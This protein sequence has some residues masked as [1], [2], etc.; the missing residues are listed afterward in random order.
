M[1]QTTLDTLLKS[2]QVTAA[3]PLG[4]ATA[5]HPGLYRS[6]DVLALEQQEIFAKEWLCL[7]RTSDIAK[8]G[9][10]LTFAI[11]DQPV[12][13]F[14]TSDGSIKTHANVCLH[15]MMRLLDGCGNAKRIVCPYHAWTYDI[16]GRLIGAP[17]MG[18]SHADTMGT[19]K[20]R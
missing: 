16:D 9:D 12:V 7:G 15:R 2:L 13:A 14:R 8:P 11:G 5:M 20:A 19:F 6:E 17:H 1:T 4:A 10:Y 3:K 18:T